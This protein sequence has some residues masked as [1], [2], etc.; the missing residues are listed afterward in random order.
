MTIFALKGFASAITGRQNFTEDEGRPELLNIEP[1]TG[2][3]AAE[4][5]TQTNT[6]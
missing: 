3:Q 5:M 1:L 4:I 2:P 6:V